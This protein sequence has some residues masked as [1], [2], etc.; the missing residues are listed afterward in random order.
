M[1]GIEH[2]GCVGCSYEDGYCVIGFYVIKRNAVES[3]EE[4]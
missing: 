3:E 4:V 2:N 1:Q